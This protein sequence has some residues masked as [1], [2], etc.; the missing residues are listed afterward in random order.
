MALIP[1]S[2]FGS[3]RKYA[4]SKSSSLPPSQLREPRDAVL[5]NGTQPASARELQERSA[6][7]IGAQPR[8]LR[9]FPHLLPASAC[10]PTAPAWHVRFGA[11]RMDSLGCTPLE[12]FPLKWGG[13]VNC[14]EELEMV[15]RKCLLQGLACSQRSAN[16]RNHH[17]PCWQAVHT[18]EV[19][20]YNSKV[21]IEN[22]VK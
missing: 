1:D 16:S 10:S 18:H 14:Y 12:S 22:K 11:M 17:S 13:N 2:R 6:F 20:L 21:K 9:C 19:I 3:I 15:H 8:S 7:L 5:A 4:G